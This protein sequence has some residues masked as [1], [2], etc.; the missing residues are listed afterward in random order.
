MVTGNNLGTVRSHITKV[1]IGEVNC[2]V[3][4]ASYRPGVG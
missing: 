2:T 4:A 3:I 1:T